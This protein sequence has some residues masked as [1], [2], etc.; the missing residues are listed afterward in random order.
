MV[1]VNELRCELDYYPETGV[2]LWACSGRGQFKRKGAKAGHLTDEGYIRVKV[3][4]SEQYAHRLAWLYVYGELPKD[5]IDHINGNRSDNRIVNLR[6]ATRAQ[7]N[8][9]SV[10]HPTR[11]MH[12]QHKGVTRT[13]SN[14]WKAQIRVCGKNL[15][16]GQFTTEEQ[17]AESYMRAAAENFGEFAKW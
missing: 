4:G 9:N 13:K 1:S 14:K 10:G 11:R 5:Q 7:N 3:C 8:R 12:S 17:A 2:F 6:E 16:L 15:N